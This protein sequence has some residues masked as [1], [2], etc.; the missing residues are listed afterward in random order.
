MN[1]DAIVKAICCLHNFLVAEGEAGQYIS[2]EDLRA[3]DEA[4]TQA[5]MRA[6]N[7]HRAPDDARDIQNALVDYF[8]GVGSVPWQ[9]EMI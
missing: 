3:A 5:A 2:E 7:A 8:N 6:T 1:A 4:L 9:D